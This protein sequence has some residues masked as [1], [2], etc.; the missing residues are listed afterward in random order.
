MSVKQIVQSPN[1]ILRNKSTKVTDFN[2]AAKIVQDLKDSLKASKIP[3]IGLSAPQIGVNKNIFIVRRYY[4][5]NKKEEYDEYTI[6]NPK[7][8]NTSRKKDKSLEACLS[9]KNT[10]GFVERYKQVTIKYQDLSKKWHEISGSKIFSHAIQHEMDHLEGVLFTDKLI[11]NKSY[12]E[13]EIDKILY[14]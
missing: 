1:K 7:L 4:I 3:G 13:K 12:T 2:E 9:I 11:D 14:G 5:K 6:I 10:F 8:V